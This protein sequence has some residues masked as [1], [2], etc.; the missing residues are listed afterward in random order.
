MA[1]YL[2]LGEILV[3]EGIITQEQL[4]KAIQ[5]QQKE[6]ARIGELL[7]KMGLVTEQDIVVALGKQLH[8]PYV[9][10]GSELLKPASDKQLDLLIPKD[11][12][13]KNLA[14]PLS[15]NMNSL[16]CAVFDPLDVI[17]IDNIRKMTGC[18]VNLVVAT[19]SDIEK[20]IDSFYG[21]RDLL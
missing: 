1:A 9:S 21:K 5:A 3:K 15:K 11:F 16:T 7:I 8:I 4:D 6:G 20:A 10:L 14:I 13:L 18:E 19:K 2:R 17:L 12:A